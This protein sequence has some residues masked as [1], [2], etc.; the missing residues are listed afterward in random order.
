MTVKSAEQDG[1][2]AQALKLSGRMRV[3][4]AFAAIV[5]NCLQHIR[6]ND[7]AV[8]QGRGM[9]SLHQMRVGLRRLRSAL[10]LFDEPFRLPPAMQNA[11]TVLLDQL[12]AAR[13][14]EVMLDATL[15]G[16]AFAAI[17]GIDTLRA[18][19]RE[20]C[21][22]RQQMVM[23]ETGS[24]H[25]LE[26]MGRVGDWCRQRGWRRTL[27]AKGR[28]YARMR[29]EEVADSILCQR[30][31]VLRKRARKLH[32]AD[33]AARHGARIAAKKL[34]YG[35]EFL[36]SLYHKRCMRRYLQSLK[37]LQDGLGVLNDLAVAQRMLQALEPQR[38][39]LAACIETVRGQLG[40]LAQ[41]RE[42][43]LRR[44]WHQFRKT[45]LPSL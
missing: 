8:A 6:A 40:L 34:R 4:Q 42:R 26:L 22:S 38:A 23:A 25:Y 29:L 36:Q 10:T 19:L 11:L 15:T 39:G 20:Q 18:V 35:S 16:D 21:R 28:K 5:G 3:E 27:P 14:L 13:D 9:E 2:E 24:R 43:G 44:L 7:R 31:R 41:T 30:H 12:G 33:D 17:N 1:V 37:A 32:K 45:E